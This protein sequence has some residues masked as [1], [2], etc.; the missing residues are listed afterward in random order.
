MND[1]EIIL[2]KLNNFK[3]YIKQISKNLGVVE[4][5][6]KLDF[7]Q[8]SLFVNTY[9]RSKKDDLKS[10]ALEFQKKL[11]FDDEHIDKITR[12]LQLFCDYMLISDKEIS[13][14]VKKLQEMQENQ[15]NTNKNQEKSEENQENL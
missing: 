4:Q 5:Y 2:E 9:L 10:V 12:Y 1:Y 14:T 3:T 11:D 8:L 6:E 13:E 7:V 15:K